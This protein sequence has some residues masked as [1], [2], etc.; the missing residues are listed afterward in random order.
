MMKPRG[1]V[2]EPG[3]WFESGANAAFQ[4]TG[5][6]PVLGVYPQPRT[7]LSHSCHTAAPW[8]NANAT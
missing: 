4:K 8:A 6:P 1:A 2:N 7:A 5:Q 3:D